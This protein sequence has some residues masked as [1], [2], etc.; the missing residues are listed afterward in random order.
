MIP[1]NTHIN[2]VNFDA[3]IQEIDM[4][5]NKYDTHAP[6]IANLCIMNE[7][8][9][10]LSIYSDQAHARDKT[11]PLSHNDAHDSTSEPRDLEGN[12]LCLRT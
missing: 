8:S 2:M 11:T 12:Q 10:S 4:E 6:Y 1:A 3:Q 9:P 7:L 5:I